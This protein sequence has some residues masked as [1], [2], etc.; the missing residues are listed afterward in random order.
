M[1]I[2][3]SI[4]FNFVVFQSAVGWEHTEYNVEKDAPREDYTT[5]FGGKF[6]V[7]EEHHQDKSALSFDYSMEKDEKHVR[8]VCSLLLSRK[9]IFLR[10][11]VEYLKQKIDTF[12]F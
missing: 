3:C 11:Y 7:Q 9:T 2:F 12:C 10:L 5:G 4:L 8:H 1:Q 6:G